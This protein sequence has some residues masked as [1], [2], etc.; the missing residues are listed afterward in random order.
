[1]RS[2]IWN[3]K[4]GGEITSK[5]VKSHPLFQDSNPEAS[6]YLSNRR[7]LVGPGCTVNS[8]F[9]GI[10]LLSGVA[11]IANLCND[12]ID[13]YATFP[14]LANITAGGNPVVG[15]KDHKNHYAAGTEAGFA[16]CTKS[17]SKLL[18]LDLAKFYKI[19]FLC[20][21][22][23][24][25]DLQS[26]SVGQDI[27]GLGLSLIQVPGSDIVTKS[28]S[29]KAP[30]EFDEV[31][32]YQCGVDASVLTS[33]NI[34][35]AFVGKAREY[36][37]TNNTENGIAK[38]AADQGRSEITLA[39]HGDSPTS[40]LKGDERD[41]VIDADLTNSFATGAVLS[42]GA[43]RPI[44][45]VAKPSDGKETFPAGTEVGF[46]Y[47][48]P[49]LLNLGIATGAT[50]TIY[51]KNNKQIAEYNISTTVLKLGLVTNSHDA[52][53][54]IKAPKAFSSVKLMLYG[55]KVNLGAD[56]VNYAFVRLAPSLASHHCPIEATSSCD[57]PSNVNSFTLQHNP[58]INVTWTIGN[59]PSNSNVE[60]TTTNGETTVTN[61]YVP[62]IYTFTATAADGCS[63]TTTIDYAPQPYAPTDNGTKLLVNEDANEPRYKL[64]DKTGGSLLQLANNVENK[65]ALLTPSLT[66]YAYRTPGVELAANSAIIGIKTADGSSL[67]SGIDND[68]N[69][70]FVVSAST[71]LDASVLSLYNIQLLKNGVKVG[72]DVTSHW[73]AISAGLIGSKETH[74]MRL[75]IDVPKGTD[76]DEMVLYNSGVLAA[77]LSQLNIH[78]AYVND[79]T[80]D[81]VVTNEL[82][83]AEPVSNETTDAS[84]DFDNTKLF[85]V[86]NIGN[87]YNELANLIDNDLTTAMQF[88]M[89]VDLGGA[90][91]SV[92]IGKTVNPGQQL[93][94]VTNKAI[95]GLGASLGEALKITTY[96]DSKEEET[97]NN[98]NVLGADIIGSNA[99]GYFVVNPK[100]PFDNIRITAVKA[101]SALNGLQFY[102]IAIRSDM[103]QDGIP[104]VVSENYVEDIM[105]D[106]NRS[107]DVAQSFDN[108]QLFFR[109][110]MTK[111]KWNSLILPVNMNKAQ[112]EA[113]FGI[114]AEIAAF[115]RLDDDCIYYKSV[116]DETDGVLL[117][118]NTPYIVKPTAEPLQKAT[119]T[120]ANGNMTI[121]GPVYVTTGISYSGEDNT[122]R[123]SVD[124]S[125]GNMTFWG[126]YENPTAVPAKS[127]MFNNGNMVHTAKTHN[128]KAYRTWLVEN[129]PSTKEL[130]MRVEKTGAT[131]GI[132]NVIEENNDSNHA[133]YD[134][135][136]IRQ[137]NS[138][139]HKGVYIMNGR[140]YTRK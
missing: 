59:Q 51:D 134:L 44:T 28:F 117:K 114:G 139:M 15:V 123:Y 58:D 132:Y 29:A 120:S 128:V 84:I 53:V 1:M 73:S 94:L 36:T 21:G 106:E 81:N 24:V 72:G 57:V 105:L 20:D 89:G 17:D 66:D 136:G 52:E 82:Y 48:M 46:K 65:E 23:T 7:A 32:L 18:G 62:G 90:T 31:K 88:P 80:K 54:I 13:D 63:E 35:Y 95:A 125:N 122:T 10:Q 115:D 67:G 130:K 98:W 110:T 71:A 101:L 16:I 30:A 22:K 129:S 6:N 4:T 8:L 127:Y 74:K 102:G 131:T 40:I 55:I 3:G 14:G 37:I 64:S 38:Y 2:C 111:N 100:K 91:I 113:A 61:L 133:I 119:Y 135:N 86:A 25:S 93:V 45:V 124:G 68:M 121:D 116:T 108:A 39:A 107:L 9:D 78:Y 83:E 77:D 126:T 69:V 118:K 49:S 41:H 140:K 75:S 50:I 79:A 42:L 12:D 19:Q 34:K 5:V 76:F 27:T 96:C 43:E 99:Q 138:S 60:L 85:S 33:I 104:D 47:N 87:G 92:N 70:G 26:I 137:S 109:R 56:V 97:L 112:F 103:D 11:N